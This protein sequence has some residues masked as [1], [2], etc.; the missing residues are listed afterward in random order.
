VFRRLRSLA[1]QG[2]NYP[3][4]KPSRFLGGGGGG[5][6]CARVCEWY[7]AGIPSVK[8]FKMFGCCVC[9]IPS[10]YQAGVGGG[11]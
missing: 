11:W 6:P 10:G 8:T 2:R 5:A 7:R 9:L 1:F 4:R 3:V